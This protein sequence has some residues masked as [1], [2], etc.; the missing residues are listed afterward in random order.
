MIKIYSILFVLI[1]ISGC[2]KTAEQVQREKR[3]ETMSEQ[4]GDTQGLMADLVNQVKSM[5]TQLDKMNGRLEVIEHRQSKLN[6][7]QIKTMEENLTLFKTQQENDSKHLIQIQSELKDQ[8]AFLEKI[9]TTLASSRAKSSPKVS[10]KK[11][12]KEELSTGLF[13]I[14]SNKYGDAKSI[15]ESLI[16]HNELNAADK[17]KVLYG[18]G[19]VEYYLGHPDKAMVYLSKIITKYPKSS[20]APSSLLF[21]GKSLNKLGKKDDAK[22][23]FQKL[24]DDYKDSKEANEARK[25]L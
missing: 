17:N 2:I 4:M 21:I 11:S 12:V 3:I 9:T 20:L 8:R 18:L 24:I 14:K 22:Q 7:E 6:P 16:N 5:Q 13:F 25:E 23:A 15:L 10:K 1:T 19:K